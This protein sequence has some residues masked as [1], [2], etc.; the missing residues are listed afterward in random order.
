[1]E[2]IKE[3]TMKAKQAIGKLIMA[4][5]KSGVDLPEIGLDAFTHELQYLIG[6]IDGMAAVEI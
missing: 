3:L 4:I 6:F 2:E 1:M 5:G